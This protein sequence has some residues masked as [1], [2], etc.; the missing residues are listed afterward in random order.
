MLIPYERSRAAERAKCEALTPEQ[1]ADIGR[2]AVAEM[3]ERFLLD[4]PL[5]DA[6]GF[7]IRSSLDD[8]LNRDGMR[9]LA[10]YVREV[11]G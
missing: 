3:H 7:E 11:L 10:R 1:L 6:H 2:R 9:A 5:K 8:A 4:D